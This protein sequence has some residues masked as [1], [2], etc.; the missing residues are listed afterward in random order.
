MDQPGTQP[1]NQTHLVTDRAE[2]KSN[3]HLG[4]RLIN[5]RCKESWSGAILEAMDH[6][7]DQWDI[8]YLVTRLHKEFAYQIASSSRTVVR[9]LKKV[10][11]KFEI[12]GHFEA[13]KAEMTVS[14]GVRRQSA[15]LA[16]LRR[17]YLKVKDH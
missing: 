14:V 13:K 15:L 8:R 17:L 3:C 12:R 7:R 2:E 9:V 16:F 11:Q 1:P 10:A 6:H 4:H 5:F